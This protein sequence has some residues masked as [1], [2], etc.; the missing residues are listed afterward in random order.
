MSGYKIVSKLRRIEKELDELGFVL[1]KPKHDWSTTDF[2]QVAIKPKD[3]NALPIYSRDAEIF[4]GS[5]E[6]LDMWLRGVEWARQYD[7][8]LKVSDQNKR[9]RKEQDVRNKQ[10]VS[11][12]KNEPIEIRD[13]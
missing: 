10:L 6:S 7:E 13:K 11:I 3:S 4:L 12:L 2:D 9:N 1:C 5:I 8:L